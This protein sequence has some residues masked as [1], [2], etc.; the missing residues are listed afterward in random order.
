MCKA[1]LFFSVTRG[2]KITDFGLAGKYKNAR[3]TQTTPRVTGMMISAF[4]VQGW[5]GNSCMSSP[6]AVSASVSLE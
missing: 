3:G 1:G 5:T 4:D 2:N 6:P